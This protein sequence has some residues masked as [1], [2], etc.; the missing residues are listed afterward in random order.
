MKALRTPVL[1]AT[2]LLTSACASRPIQSPPPSPPTAERSAS[3]PWEGYNR[4]IYSVN[5]TLDK[6]LIR[7]VAVAY[8]WVT[9]APVQASVTRLFGN[10]REPVTAVNQALQM[11]PA[12]AVQSLG[13]FVVNSTVGVGGLFDP[14][15][16]FGMAREQ[17][18]F[19]QTLATWG[20]RDSRYVILP[21][22]GPRT[23]RDTVGMIGDQPLSPI[24]RIDSAGVADKLTLLQ[25]ADGRARGLQVDGMRELALDEYA[26]VRDAWLNRRAQQIEIHQ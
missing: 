16:R 4:R 6:V 25:M 12:P 18:D 20:W 7:P 21:L 14:A 13:R 22:L 1:V 23:V 5:S 2:V 11:R 19:G 24:S 17:E 10:L 26:V 15:T 9:P 8:D 3:D